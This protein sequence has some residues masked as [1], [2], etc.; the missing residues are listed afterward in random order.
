LAACVAVL[1]SSSGCADRAKKEKP[2]V[3][4][5]VSATVLHFKNAWSCQ[6]DKQGR[7]VIRG[8]SDWDEIWRKSQTRTYP[9]KE[10]PAQPPPLIDFDKSM[11][12]AAFRGSCG[13]TGYRVKIAQVTETDDRINAIVEY[14]SPGPGQVESDIVTYPFT[15]VSVP[16]SDK[17]VDFRIVVAGGSG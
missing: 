15:M 7:Y 17:P 3:G 13:S 8:K 12:L 6:H 11:I 14:R 1:V 10:P 2:P 4:K 16:K 9:G 5:P